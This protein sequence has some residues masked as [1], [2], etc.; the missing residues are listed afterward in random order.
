M[1]KEMY[2]ALFIKFLKENN[3]YSEYKELWTDNRKDLV[4]SPNMKEWLFKTN[5][6]NYLFS[7]FSWPSDLWCPLHNRWL[8]LIA[9]SEKLYIRHG[10]EL[11]TTRS[12]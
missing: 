9:K 7:A 11:R 6:C 3:V 12:I 4:A 1:K 8:K 10:K 5:T 2:I